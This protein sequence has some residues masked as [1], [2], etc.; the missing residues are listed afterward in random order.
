[1]LTSYVH[2]KFNSTVINR[3]QSTVDL[4]EILG[5]H[6]GKIT[7]IVV[8]KK[9]KNRYSIF[10]NEIFVVGVSDG[11]IAKYKL[12]KDTFF[13]QLLFETII[14]AEREWAVKNYMIALLS[15]R[16]HSS[17][18]LKTKAIKKG[19][20][21]SLIKQI[22]QE[23]N[24]KG[25]INNADFAKKYANDKF[26]FNAWGP[27][28]IQIELIKKGIERKHITDALCELSLDEQHTQMSSI[29]HKNRARFKRSLPEKRKKKIFDFFIRK[30]YDSNALSKKLPQWLNEL[31]I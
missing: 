3:N 22:I 29:F 31:E 25:Y 6:S 24:E 26:R 10:V 4:K 20:D 28:K 19:Y 23:L 27:I 1:M 16:D 2:S 13:D 21:I 30:G 14:S 12:S 7:S 17:E 8:Q 9:N 11:T 18:E 5:T 15:R